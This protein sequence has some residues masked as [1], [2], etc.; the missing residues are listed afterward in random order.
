MTSITMPEALVPLTDAAGRFSMLAIDQRESL[1]TMIGAV[2]HDPVTDADLTDFKTRAAQALTPH[3]SAVLLDRFQGLGAAAVRDPECAFILAA[4][5]LH[6][7]PGGPVT[8]A[9]LD[10]DLTVDMIHAHG[11]DALKMLVPWLPG[12]RDAAIELAG[13]FMDLCTAAGLPGIVEGVVRPHDIASWT[14]VERNDA[15]VEAAKDLATVR[16][17]LYKAEVPSYGR[18]SSAELTTEATRIS[19]QLDCPWVVLSS[20]VAPADFPAAVAACVE[21]GADGFL[22]GRAVWSDAI[23]ASD[24]DDFLVTESVRRLRVL[25]GAETS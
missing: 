21:G 12:E 19:G 15:L 13:R 3:A 25:S 24:V 8:G 22:A 17:S 5:I 4:D 16:P 7:E 1:R 6:Q 2:T 23:S 14:D 9:S 20:G 10:E 18:G 11:A